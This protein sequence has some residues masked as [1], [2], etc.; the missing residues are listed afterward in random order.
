MSADHDSFVASSFAAERA[1]D[2]ETALEYH[3]G[4][5]MFS[6]SSHVA[7]LTQLAGLSEEM[8]PW[9]WA[10]WAAYQCTRAEETGTDSQHIVHAALDYTLRM[11]YADVLADAYAAGADP[12]SQMAGVLG[13]DWALHQ[14]CTFE[15]G[16]QAL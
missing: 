9:L 5:P 15:L 14:V 7:L 12:M 4:I 16:G 1:G 8:T 10:R 11:F 13:E 6:R 3:R 2:A